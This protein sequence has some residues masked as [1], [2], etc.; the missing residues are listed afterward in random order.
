M[1]EI[2]KGRVGYTT[3]RWKKWMDGWLGTEGRER[4]KLEDD[5]DDQDNMI[6]KAMEGNPDIEI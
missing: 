6:V 1:E 5:Q 4:N 2:K 3:L